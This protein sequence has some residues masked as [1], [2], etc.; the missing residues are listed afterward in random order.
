MGSPKALLEYR[1]ETFIARL[2][3]IFSEVCDPVIV[4]LGFHADKIGP[5]IPHG[6]Q[7]VI[8]PTPERGQLSSLQ[9]GL[10][11]LPAGVEGFLFLP[12]DCPAVEASTVKQVVDRFLRRDPATQCVVPQ[13]RGKHGHP[14]CAAPSLA[15]EFLALPPS[16]QA[17]DVVHAHVPHTVYL[18]VDDPGILRDVDDPE[19]YRQMVEASR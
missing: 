3:R 16:A 5:R 17:R 8:N 13:Y 1:G 19:A 15:R 4:V 11:A 2:V 10:A 9:T 6:A 12:V 7:V 18:D 14:V